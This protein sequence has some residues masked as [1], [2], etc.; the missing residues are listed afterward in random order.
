[1]LGKENIRHRKEIENM[2]NR[3]RKFVYKRDLEVRFL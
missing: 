2:T 3:V 1:M